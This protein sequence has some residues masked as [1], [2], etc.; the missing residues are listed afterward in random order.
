MERAILDE[1]SLEDADFAQTDLRGSSLRNTVLRGANLTGAMLA[2][3]EAHP[4]LFDGV[5]ADWVDFS[6]RSG[7]V[8]VPG[9]QLREYFERLRGGGAPGAGPVLAP[10]PSPT[11]GSR[12]FFGEG[13]VLRNAALEFGESSVVEIESRFE[14]CTIVLREGAMLTVGPRGE[15]HGCRVEGPGEIV[16]HGR[17]V[18]TGDAPALA[19]ARRLLVSRTG[20]IAGALRQHA[21]LTRIALERGCRLDLAIQRA[22]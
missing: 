20:S 3:V 14:N 15:L 11:G 17:I 7:T 10:G 13:D 21:D 19:G 12:R 22:N 1:A 9:A 16:V 5:R 4:E 6:T 18:Q 8:K 2:G